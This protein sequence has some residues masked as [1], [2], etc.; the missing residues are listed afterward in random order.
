MNKTNTPKPLSTRQQVYKV[1]DE[2]KGNRK[3]IKEKIAELGIEIKPT[4]LSL[5]ITQ[6]SKMDPNAVQVKSTRQQVYDIIDEANFDVDKVRQG[7]KKKGIDLKEQTMKAYIWQ[8]K[9]MRDGINPNKPISSQVAKTE[10]TTQ[11]K[12][13]KSA[14][15][16]TAKDKKSKSVKK[17][18]K[19]DD[20]QI[21]KAKR[22]ASSKGT[23][24][25]ILVVQAPEK[26]QEKPIEVMTTKK[27]FQDAVRKMDFEHEY[28][29]DDNQHDIRFKADAKKL[30]TAKFFDLL[31]QD[32]I[33][34]KDNPV[35]YATMV[36]DRKDKG[37]WLYKLGE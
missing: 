18:T 26:I 37:T 17:V 12:D 20:K 33:K 4:T 22:K 19:D 3:A 36:Q 30:D 2:C 32:E 16:S 6:K 29:D 8:K 35:I 27:C 10:S 1:Y 25:V 9:K 15:A 13:K 34:S 24:K 11:D 21:H 14:S 5:Y 28:L 23:D 31:K 7:I